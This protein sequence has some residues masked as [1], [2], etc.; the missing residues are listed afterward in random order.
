MVPGGTTRGRG[1]PMGWFGRWRNEVDIGVRPRHIFDGTEVNLYPFTKRGE[2]WLFA[3]LDKFSEPGWNQ[4]SRCLELSEF[5]CLGLHLIVD[6]LVK[7]GLTVRFYG[8]L[9]GWD[10]TRPAQIHLSPDRMSPALTVEKRAQL[11][12]ATVVL[13]PLFILVSV[14]TFIVCFWRLGLGLIL[15]L[16]AAAIIYPVMLVTIA[17]P[18]GY[19]LGKRAAKRF[20]GEPGAPLPMNIFR[21]ALARYRLAKV[22]QKELIELC[23]RVG[24]D[25]MSLNTQLHEHILK[26][27]IAHDARKA[28]TLLLFIRYQAATGETD[29]P[30]PLASEEPQAIEARLNKLDTT[31]AMQLLRDM[32]SLGMARRSQKEPSE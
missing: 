26:H 8:R 19:V 2:D 20:K 24:I 5:D 32:R 13:K 27:A 16:V 17:L 28:A 31:E 25:F 23:S 18:I 12:G 6:R 3:N 7:A 1:T 4:P 15:S 14:I 22:R 29:F 9:K 30:F 10:G 11:E 21:N